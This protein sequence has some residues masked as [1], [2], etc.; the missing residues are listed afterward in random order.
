MRKTYQKALQRYF[1]SNILL[2]RGTLRLTQ[3]QMA[4][5]LC[6][7]ER[8]YSDLDRGKTCCSAVTLALYIAFLCED[9]Q[10]FVE[11]LRNAFNADKNSAA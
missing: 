1:R 3:S 4:E 9:V 6:M 2:Y 8:A 5:R 10:K 11:G 7:D